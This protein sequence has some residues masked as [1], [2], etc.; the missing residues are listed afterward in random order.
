M[1]IWFVSC[2]AGNLIYV[3]EKGRSRKEIKEIF[4]EYDYV[5]ELMKAMTPGAFH[6]YIDVNT[7]T[8]VR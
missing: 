4:P 1:K 7:E 8:K 3:D 5:S 6:I 2:D